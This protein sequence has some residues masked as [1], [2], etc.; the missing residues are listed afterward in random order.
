MHGLQNLWQQN[1]QS[2]T[3]EQEKDMS[4]IQTKFMQQ[5]LLCFIDALPSFY[6]YMKTLHVQPYCT[7]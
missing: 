2:K 6:T 7:F 3:G 4:I 1:P 5:L